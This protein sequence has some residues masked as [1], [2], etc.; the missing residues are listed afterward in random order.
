MSRR[1]GRPPSVV[2]AVAER[3][4]QAAELAAIAGQELLADPRTNP[5]TRRLRDELRDEQ[6]RRAL[7]AAHARALRRLRV[8]DARAADAEETL[9]AIAVARQTASP[10]RSVLALHVGRRRYMRAALAASVVLAAGSALGVE[11]AAHAL[12][13][14]PGTGLAAE[15][16]LTGLSTIAIHYRAH[17]AEHRGT[18]HAGSWHSRALWLLMT[19]PLAISVT[20]NMA[21]LNIIGG[22]CAM[23]A[24][25]F[26]ALA[27]VV[28]D[29]SA[30][31][32]QDRAAEV[33][34]T[35][36]QALRD[37]AMGVAVAGVP[38]AEGAGGDRPVSVWPVPVG[39]R[40]L[41]PV[42]AR[43]VGA[44]DQGA[45]R[46]DSDRDDSDRDD[47]DA[48]QGDADVSGPHGADERRRTPLQESD[49]VRALGRDLVREA[50][51][52]LAACADASGT[53]RDERELSASG[54]GVGEQG[55][56]AHDDAGDQGRGTGDEHPEHP[57]RPQRRRRAR[58]ARPVGPAARLA[59][60]RDLLAREP[61]LSS[62]QI[63]ARL[64]IPPSTARRLAARVRGEL[65]GRDA[66]DGGER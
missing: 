45:D 5:A 14:P 12:D 58:P 54:G 21:T 32:M 48:D 4:R 60:V 3:T 65:G 37:A 53:V 17:L 39:D 26:S 49:D 7:R 40:T 36:E 64:G 25:A 20:A 23:G 59:A 55:A 27:W 11:A 29:R 47:A 2:A 18:V 31:A 42:V 62:S 22:L 6:Q 9:R 41:L 63:S 28:A 51:R 1:T 24:A 52:Y 13:A 50:E 38:T 43:T 10:A 46:D 33:S 15:V 8:Q 35:D 61:H 34:D 66:Q 19:L 16:G 56:P 44:S 57:E 30:A